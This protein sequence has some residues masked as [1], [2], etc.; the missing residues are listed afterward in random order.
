MFDLE[1]ERCMTF[2]LALH[3]RCPEHYT[4]HLKTLGERLHPTK[5]VILSDVITDI[6]RLDAADMDIRRRGTT[7]T[8]TS[9]L[10]FSPWY[11]VPMG[12]A[13][14]AQGRYYA[15]STY[16]VLQSALL[17]WHVRAIRRHSAVGPGDPSEPDRRT[18]RNVS[19]GFFYS[20][21]AVLV[22][23]ALVY[24]WVNGD[25]RGTVEF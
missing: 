20:S 23:E 4:A 6:S 14:F 18:M 24:G 10:S 22:I 15:G 17:A 5:I 12:G 25:P 13:Q 1:L 19:A 9:L 2:A 7:P 3:L 11:L 21:V 16:F 8:Y